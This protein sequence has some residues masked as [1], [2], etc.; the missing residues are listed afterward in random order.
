MTLYDMQQ[1]NSILTVCL[2]V[3]RFLLM[4]Y[5]IEL[6]TWEPLKDMIPSTHMPLYV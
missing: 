6:D 1:A 2:S 4:M 5:F 3:Y